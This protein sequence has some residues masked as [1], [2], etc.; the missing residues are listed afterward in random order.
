MYKIMRSLENICI[1]RNLLYSKKLEMTITHP[2]T[3]PYDHPLGKWI[4]DMFMKMKEN[5]SFTM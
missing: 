1:Y 5:N 2:P 4:T 3:L